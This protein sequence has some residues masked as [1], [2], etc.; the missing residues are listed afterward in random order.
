MF[1]VRTLR[2]HFIAQDPLYFPVHKSGNILRGAFGLILREV[3]GEEDYTRLFEPKPAANGPSGLADLPRPFVF[4]AAHLD[5]RGVAPGEAFHFDVN[6][7]TRDPWPVPHFEA[8]FRQLATH[9]LGPG[10]GK[11]LLQAMDLATLEFSFH[12]VPARR[13]TVE[14][15]TPT[16]LKG[17]ETSAFALL[18]A[19]LRDRISNLQG[20][21]DIDYRAL[22]H[23]ARAVRITHSDLRQV[24]A[25]RTSSRTGQTH[26]LSGFIGETTYEGELA[27]FMPYLT[28]GQYTGVGR[29]T[30]WGKGQMRVHE[31]GVHESGQAVAGNAIR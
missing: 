6:L 18:I 30:V 8:A 23:L 17:G 5:G 12:P 1:I 19:R 24:K 25:E 13:V 3:A 15:V 20:P 27:P 21:L 26:A 28:I 10:R 7:L 22:A 9:G 4:R 16:E 2:F 14:F 31:S 11:A 29:Q